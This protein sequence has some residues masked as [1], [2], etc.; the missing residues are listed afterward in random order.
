MNAAQARRAARDWV[1]AN[2]PGWPGL[3]AAHLVG[4]ITTMP[5][6][7]P[8][9]PSK[10]VDVHLIFEPG[11]PIF[12]QTGPFMP[13]LEEHAGGVAIEAGLRTA[14]EYASVDAILANPEIA[15]HLTTD[16]VL[17][18]PTGWLRALQPAIRRGYAE[19]RWV[20]ARIDH[21]RRGHAAAVALRPT[22]AAMGGRA[23]EVNILG[24][25]STYLGPAL[26]V[27]LLRS[28][29]VGNRYFVRLGDTL[30]ALGQGDLAE[31]LFE[32]LGLRH[33]TRAFVEAALAGTAEAFDLA[34]AVRRTPNYF[35]HKLHP[36]LR[37]YLVDACAAMIAEGRHREALAW[38]T[39]YAC[40]CTD[41]ILA[42]GPDARKAEFAARRDAFLAALGF[43][44]QAAVDA[45]FAAMARVSARVFALAE[46]LAVG[47]HAVAA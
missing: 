5:P 2:A 9:P 38:I 3:L 43:P 46:S 41:A 26:D 44:D 22:A 34:V 10:D 28:P 15:H 39:P 6:D 30:R 36:H 16:A 17:Y 33:A 32:L 31:E 11:S 27:A 1:N 24:Y 12:A 14:D 7:A 20:R 21:E 40:A 37:P 4:G 45:G 13:I 35:Q 25:S 47:D 23:G 42:D 29:R 18:D 8:V 19:P